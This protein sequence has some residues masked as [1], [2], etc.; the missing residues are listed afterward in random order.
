M[1]GGNVFKSL[2]N[3]WRN[4]TPKTKNTIKAVGA[5]VGTLAAL[6]GARSARNYVNSRRLQANMLT[7]RHQ[8]FLE[9]FPGRI[10]LP[11]AKP[12]NVPKRPY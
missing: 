7:N 3:R 1:F 8:T 4:A 9:R 12:V 6:A 10:P 5:V 2:K 11:V